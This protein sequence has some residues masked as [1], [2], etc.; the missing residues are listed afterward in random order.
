MGFVALEQRRVRNL[1]WGERLTD[2]LLADATEHRA[3][4][5]AAQEELRNVETQLAVLA[6]R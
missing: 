4:L 1:L 3:R 5:E 6:A 2:E